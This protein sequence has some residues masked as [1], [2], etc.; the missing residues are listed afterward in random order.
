MAMQSLIEARKLSKSYGSFTAVDAIDLAV[1]EGE[2]LTLLGASGSGKTTTLR[3]IAGLEQPSSGAVLYRG[4]DITG[5]PT[6]RR[7]MRMVFQ[8]YAL[9]PHLN[10]FD[11]VAFG[12][13][14]ASNRGRF[15][16]ASVLTQVA[17][18]LEFVQLAGQDRKMPHE[19]S[20]GQKQRVAL[21]RALVSDPPVV[22]FDEPL[23]SL[24]ASLRRA[25]QL[26]LKRIHGQLGKTFIYVTHDQEEAMAMSDRIVVMKDARILQVDTPE[27]LYDEPAS[28]AVA[29]FV[30]AANVLRGRVVS[31]EA[32]SAA[33]DFGCGLLEAAVPAAARGGLAAGAE[34]SVCLRAEG[35]DLA[36][37]GPG[38]GGQGLR[39]EGLAG[40]IA[41]CSFLG[42]A[43]EYQVALEPAGAT[44]AVI[45]DRAH[46]VHASGDA[47]TATVRPGGARVLPRVLPN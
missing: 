15:E 44:L 7:E 20:G 42:R 34:V 13:R 22:L 24:D 37:R 33:V 17:R 40:V 35:I 14:L 21:A 39:G 26:E 16:E 3:L 38:G 32:A 11:N 8:D 29:R 6:R 41:D 30:G 43:V 1:R 2:F 28:D 12:L 45:C 10:V 36:R 18:H 4:M 5:V 47:V 25:M 31:L 46:A 23:G 9:F 27:K 19:L